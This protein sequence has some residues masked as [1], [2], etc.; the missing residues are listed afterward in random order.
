MQML[1]SH[2]IAVRPVS[3]TASQH[4]KYGAVLQVQACDNRGGGPAALRMAIT[5]GG[6]AGD[7]WRSCLCTRHP[8]AASLARYGST[9]AA[10][11]F[12]RGV[13]DGNCNHQPLVCY[14]GCVAGGVRC[15]GRRTAGLARAR[16]KGDRGGPCTWGWVSDFCSSMLP[17]VG[18]HA[19]P[20][21]P[22]LTDRLPMSRC[23]SAAEV[24]WHH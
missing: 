4:Q 9:G 18:C 22:L 20:Q 11:E 5:A 17:M 14:R 8:C 13:G 24:G 16:N 23:F 12:L 15:N 10:H 21:V 6:Q 1:A 7:V 2:L 19:K 3:A